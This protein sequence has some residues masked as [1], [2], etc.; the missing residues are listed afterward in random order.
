MR[1]EVVHSTRATDV[2][3]DGRPIIAREYNTLAPH[4]HQSQN[5]RLVPTR[6]IN[7]LL[8][9]DSTAPDRLDGVELYEC[10]ECGDVF[11]AAMSARGHLPSHNP[12]TH[13]PDTD[14]RVLR[15]LVATA[16]KYRVAGKRG[17][18]ERTAAEL[19]QLGV[20]TR[21]GEPWN[22]SQVSSLYRH[23][24]DRPELKR[25]RTTRTPASTAPKTTPE[26]PNDSD[27][28]GVDVVAV[29]G[30]CDAVADH[31]R[32]LAAAVSS[33]MSRIE[34]SLHNAASM[35]QREAT[36]ATNVTPAELAELRA[37]ADQYDQLAKALRSFGPTDR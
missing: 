11:D 10:D 7:K 5:G 33:A 17:F 1:R 9:S 30:D 25:V 15:Q 18:C 4:P 23:W 24:R 12:V 37:K 31:L 3:P 32:K 26:P 13:A 36:R 2:T 19:N 14:I 20:P 34:L 16:N 6:G 22:P 27:S 21:S 29:N 28:V 8:V 35:V